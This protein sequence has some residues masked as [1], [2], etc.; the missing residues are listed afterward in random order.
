MGASTIGSLG[1]VTA[2]T[3]GDTMTFASSFLPIS[4]VS[5][6]VNHANRMVLMKAC[7]N[8]PSRR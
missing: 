2:G 1:A 5:S 8:N 4:T 6:T 3:D 7:T